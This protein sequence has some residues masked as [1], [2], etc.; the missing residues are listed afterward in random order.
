MKA[1]FVEE[2]IMTYYQITYLDKDEKGFSDHEPWVEDNFE[3]YSEAKKHK[4]WMEQEGYKSV[5]IIER[6]D[7]KGYVIAKI[8]EGVYHAGIENI[9]NNISEA[10]IYK[11]KETAKSDLNKYYSS[12]NW[13]VREIEISYA[14][15]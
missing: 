12:N 7:E 4:K 15:Y 5:K 11:N 10:F 14:I 9:V 3:S 1:V 8:N 6:A 2:F 13:E